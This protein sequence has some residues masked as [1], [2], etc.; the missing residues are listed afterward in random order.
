MFCFVTASPS[1]EPTSETEEGLS[2]SAIA[3]FVIAVA[4]FVFC[5]FCCPLVCWFH[6]LEYKREKKSWTRRLN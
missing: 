4:G 1:P 5:C 6:Y 2:G 3:G